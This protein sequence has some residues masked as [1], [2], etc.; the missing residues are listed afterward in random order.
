MDKEIIVSASNQELLKDKKL[1]S[2]C[3]KVIKKHNEAREK[4]CKKKE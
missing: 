2:S 4:A 3:Y 1:M